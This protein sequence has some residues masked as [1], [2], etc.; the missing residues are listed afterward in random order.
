MKYRFGFWNKETNIS[1]LVNSRPVH[2]VHEFLKQ[3]SVAEKMAKKTSHADFIT[4]QLCRKQDENIVYILSMNG[5]V[6]IWPDNYKHYLYKHNVLPEKKFMSMVT[7]IYRNKIN[8]GFT[9]N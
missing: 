4:C 5:D 9:R 6:Y 7:S 2:N 1:D 3:M 8:I